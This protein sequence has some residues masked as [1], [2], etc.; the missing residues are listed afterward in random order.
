MAVSLLG[1]LP[2]FLV[3]YKSL[4]CQDGSDILLKMRLSGVAEQNY[5]VLY[6]KSD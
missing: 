5:I 4:N 6:G 3:K 2:F 1:R